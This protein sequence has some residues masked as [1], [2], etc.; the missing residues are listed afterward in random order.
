MTFSEYYE[1]ESV[2]EYVLKM[3]TEIQKY[4]STC[5]DKMSHEN[6][7]VYSNISTYTLIEVRNFD[8][9]KIK[10]FSRYLKLM[11]PISSFQNSW[12]AWFF[13]RGVHTGYCQYSNP[14]FVT[15][16]ISTDHAIVIK[17]RAECETTNTCGN[18]FSLYHNPFISN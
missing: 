6:L 18:L 1:N 9:S 8:N 10:L 13:F 7:P 15:R 11:V 16:L 17:Q 5:I 4:I 3:Y 2:H 14:L 12:S